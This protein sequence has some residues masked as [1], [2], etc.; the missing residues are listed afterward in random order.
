MVDSDVL[1]AETENTDN[2]NVSVFSATPSLASR[3]IEYPWQESEDY[4]TYQNTGD[5][6]SVQ[7]QDGENEHQLS[8]AQGTLQ[9]FGDATPI[10]DTDVYFY[11]TEN[12]YVAKWQYKDFVVSLTSDESLST[13]I[14]KVETIME[15]NL[16]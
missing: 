11:V 16:T 13:F 9:G 15:E 12:G 4:Y 14:R 2:E 10:L 1:F 7:I 3:I 5:R 6:F 8:M